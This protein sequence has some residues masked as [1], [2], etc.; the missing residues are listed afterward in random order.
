MLWCF[1]ILIFKVMFFSVFIFIRYN[2]RQIY[3]LNA[4]K[5]VKRYLRIAVF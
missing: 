1:L 5:N 2:R 3:I 4:F